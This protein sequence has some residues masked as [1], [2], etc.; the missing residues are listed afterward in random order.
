MI[1][2]A[3][4]YIKDILNTAPQ[5]WIIAI[6]KHCCVKTYFKATRAGLF[7]LHIAVVFN[8]FDVVSFLLEECSGINVNV[9]TNDNYLYTPL[10]LT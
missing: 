9:T 1:Y 5:S 10:H 6:I 3:L 2:Q 8:C 4:M 7:L